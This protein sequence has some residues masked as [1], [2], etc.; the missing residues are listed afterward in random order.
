MCW[1]SHEGLWAS[2]IIRTEQKTSLGSLTQTRWRCHCKNPCDADSYHDLD[3][4]QPSC[5]R[6]LISHKTINQCQG[7]KNFFFRLTTAIC[8]CL[9]NISVKCVELSRVRY[10][11]SLVNYFNCVSPGRVIIF[12]IILECLPI[13]RNEHL[14]GAC[15]SR[16]LLSQQLWFITAAQKVSRNN[17]LLLSDIPTQMRKCCSNFRRITSA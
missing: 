10:Y 8:E 14:P 3:T 9:C 7:L 6:K 16:A 15:C 4:N 17:I 11:H 12:T 1:S 13:T 2:W 5:S